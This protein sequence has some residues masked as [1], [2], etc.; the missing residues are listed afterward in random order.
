MGRGGIDWFKDNRNTFTFSGNHMQG[1]FDPIDTLKTKTDTIYPSYEDFSSYNRISKTKR[2][3]ENTGL[4]FQ[5]KHIFPRE[6]QEFTSDLNYN[7][8]Q[9]LSAGDPD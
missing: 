9:F 6:G 8:S 2:P 7:K 3:F 4:S 1:L 5:Y